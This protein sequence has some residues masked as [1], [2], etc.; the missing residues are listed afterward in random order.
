MDNLGSLLKLP[1]TITAK[2]GFASDHWRE[3]NDCSK[4]VEYAEKAEMKVIS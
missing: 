3:N 1:Q 4:M 2:A